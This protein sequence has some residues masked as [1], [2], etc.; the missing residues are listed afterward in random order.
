MT[1][2]I[3]SLRLGRVFRILHPMLAIVANHLISMALNPNGTDL[4]SDHTIT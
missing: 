1:L 3:V 2:V 4:S